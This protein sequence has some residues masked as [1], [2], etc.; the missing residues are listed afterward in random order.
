MKS[1]SRISGAA[2]GH[3]CAAPLIH[4][5]RERQG[6]GYRSGVR[7]RPLHRRPAPTAH[8]DGPGAVRVAVLDYPR[9]DPHQLLVDLHAAGVTYP[10]VLRAQGEYQIKPNPPFVPGSEMA[11]TVITAPEGSGFRF[12][13]RVAPFPGLGGFAQKVAAD[14]AVVFPCPHICPARLKPGF[15]CGWWSSGPPETLAPALSRHSARTLGST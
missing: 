1:L 12:G 8:L 5:A 11:G 2:L 3:C 14:A 4:P 10:D 15:R 7:P 6:E 13:D 9:R